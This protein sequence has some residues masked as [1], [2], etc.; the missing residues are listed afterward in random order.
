MY[1]LY[2][3]HSGDQF[4]SAEFETAES[5]S[6]YQNLLNL[7]LGGDF[8]EIKTDSEK[9]ILVL[10]DPEFGYVAFKPQSWHFSQKLADAAI[11]ESR[12]A[13]AKWIDLVDSDSVECCVIEKYVFLFNLKKN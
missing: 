9:Q 12:E 5:A 1:K 3:K 13:A 6:K 2:Y 11:F 7:V 10:K 8:L 4:G